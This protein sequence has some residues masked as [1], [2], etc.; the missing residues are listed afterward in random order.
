MRSW[1]PDEVV[2][3]DEAE[4]HLSA[5]LVRIE[6]G[7]YLLFVVPGSFPLTLVRRFRSSPDRAEATIDEILARVR[8]AGAPGLRWAVN[9]RSRPSDL[10]E[11]LLRRGFGELAAAETLYFGLGTRDE[12][13]L[14]DVPPRA[15]IAT[16]E[17]T[18]DAEVEEF[19]RL[20]ETIFGDPR[21]PEKYLQG[22]RSEVR[23]T[24]RATGHSELFLVY[25]GATPVGR[26]GLSVMGRV[27]RLWTAGVLPEHR[28]KGAYLAL[29][30]ERCRVA[31]ELGAE[32]ALTH[33]KVGTSGPILRSLGFES[34]GPYLY[35]ELRSIEGVR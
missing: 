11:R 27:G 10:R 15:G 2:A 9:S 1:T 8:E 16:R 32:L 24:I 13:R 17:A 29:T 30:R 7:E 28:G 23:E 14:P 34:A 35:Y 26:G 18:T 22:F 4:T 3:L 5:P 6:T 33:A 12:P 25:D 19:V 21:P 20:G 31:L